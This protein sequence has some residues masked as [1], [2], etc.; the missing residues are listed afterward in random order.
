MVSSKL[1]MIFLIPPN[2]TFLKLNLPQKAVMT[3]MVK[4]TQIFAWS[5]CLVGRF[6]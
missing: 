3:L 1:I 2:I 5:D 6:W 4:M